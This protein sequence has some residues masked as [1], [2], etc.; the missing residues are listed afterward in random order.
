MSEWLEDS[1]DL[2]EGLHSLDI[3]SCKE[4]IRQLQSRRER[5]RE[6]VERLQEKL[7][8]LNNEL[9]A[10]KE[11]A[12]RCKKE[13]LEEQAANR[14]V[15]RTNQVAI[16]G[17]HQREQE[18]EMQSSN[19]RRFMETTLQE[20]VQRR[21][22]QNELG[23]RVYDEVELMVEKPAEEQAMESK[24]IDTVLVTYCI[25][26]SELKYNLSFR[27]DKG[28][29]TKKLREDACLYWGLSEVE[30]I[31]KTMSNAKV[32]DELTIQSCFRENEDAHFSL[33]QKTPKNASLMEREL[34]HILPRA[35]R[36]ARRTGA[37]QSESAKGEN[38][39]AGPSAELAEQMAA[40]PG[41]FQYMTQRDQ[42]VVQH[43]QRLKLRNLCVYLAVF[44]M[45]IW[46]IYMVIPPDK[47]FNVREGIV[48]LMAEG[49]GR[50]VGFDD[51][52]T[53]SQVWLWLGDTVSDQLFIPASALR[54]YNAPVGYMQVLLQDVQ[55][56]SAAQCP[57]GSWSPLPTNVDCLATRYWDLTA[58]TLTRENITAYFA[59]LAGLDGRYTGS[60]PG[61]YGDARSTSAAGEASFPGYFYDFDGSGF[62]V[63]YD[64]QHSPLAD[65]RAAF[66]QDMQFLQDEEWLS[67]QSRAIHVNFLL[68]NGNHD[69]FV[70]NRYSFE[71][72]AVGTVEPVV[73]VAAFRPAVVEYD[74][75]LELL[76]TDI[77]RL[78]LVLLICPVQLISDFLYE[79][80]VNEAGCRHCISL[81]GLVDWAIGI[82]S[83]VMFGFRYLT[84]SAPSVNF[85]VQHVQTPM[86][87]GELAEMFNIHLA[88]DALLSA[89]LMYR[90]VYFLRVNRHVFLMW[91]TVASSVSVGLRL[92]VIV[93]PLM[94]GLV[95][96][97]MAVGAALDE[98]NRTFWSAMVRVLLMVY[99]DN[100]TIQ[101]FDPN[102]S[103][104]LAFNVILVFTFKLVFV[105]SWIA[106]LIHQYQRTRVSAGYSTKKYRW[107]EYNFVVWS[108]AWPFRNLY[109]NFLRPRIEM[110]PKDSAE[111]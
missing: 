43:L 85:Y 70:S 13:L 50:G 110:P 27:V 26:N 91:S 17:D 40:L 3:T 72:T 11:E 30:F 66:Q 101:D 81:Q 90:F 76:L 94:A 59:G 42:K 9:A 57:Q 39:K 111:E 47:S 83:F 88:V 61:T 46:D 63:E 64:L 82:L 109:L 77:I 12:D 65:V 97:S 33:V 75:G 45:T 84:F 58:D 36:K 56:A 18:L 99:G 21:S 67:A 96:I 54:S 38:A 62:S 51:I 29:K 79:R 102:N 28:M 103:W 105:N 24:Y 104:Q 7:K 34:L 16:Q 78:C 49:D 23:I 100:D 41:L 22:M 60:T 86:D 69:Q 31:L 32:H 48:Q 20:Q 2:L 19:V 95:L 74:M 68:Y 5:R 14:R 15:V 73:Q 89:L 35:G 87:A 6:L 93:I 1:N 25:P 92:A 53:Q 44:I 4:H 10:R 71:M 8:A 37:K 98:K 80:R 106:V 107:K 55:P 52:R 108:L